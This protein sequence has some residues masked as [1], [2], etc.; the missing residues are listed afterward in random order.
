M[1]LSSLDKLEIMKDDLLDVRHQLSDMVNKLHHYRVNE[2][3]T[4]VN[5]VEDSLK[6][7]AVSLEMLDDKMRSL[8]LCSH[9]IE[10]VA[11]T[12]EKMATF[13][14]LVKHRKEV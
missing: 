11:R 3:V 14:K 8:M 7:Q 5:S 2:Y 10:S 1:A 4:L 9:E 6:E 13:L 12:L